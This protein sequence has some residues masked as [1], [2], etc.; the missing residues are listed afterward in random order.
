MR[1][2]VKTPIPERFWPKVECGATGDCWPWRAARTDHG[3][4]SF[5]NGERSVYAHRIAYE[6]LIGPIPDGL[7]IDH[8]CRNRACCN[9]AHLEA[10]T[11]AENVLRGVSPTAANALKTHCHRGHPFDAENTYIYGAGK[12]S[13]RICRRE[14]KLQARE[15]CGQKVRVQS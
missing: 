5:W 15:A 2:Y 13:C 10:V 1:V 12:R 4:G 7:D 3:Y 14:R 11:H 6:L 8:L 9:P